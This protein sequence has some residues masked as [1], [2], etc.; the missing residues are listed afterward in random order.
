MVS[1]AVVALLSVKLHNLKFF[2]IYIISSLCLVS[3]CSILKFTFKCQ[4][5]MFL[6]QIENG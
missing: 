1:F 5:G 2:K 4:E 6:R 3:E